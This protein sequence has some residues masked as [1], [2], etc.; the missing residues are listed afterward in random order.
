MFIL[1]IRISINM[2]ELLIYTH[3]HTH[4]HTAKRVQLLKID[5]QGYASVMPLQDDEIDCLTFSEKREQCTLQL[6]LPVC[7]ENDMWKYQQDPGYAP[8]VPRRES[9]G[10]TQSQGN[11]IV[12]SAIPQDYEVPLNCLPSIEQTSRRNSHVLTRQR[13]LTPETSTEDDQSKRLSHQRASDVGTHYLESDHDL[14]D[15]EE[16]F[17]DSGI[18]TSVDSQD[19]VLKEKKRWNQHSG[20]SEVKTSARASSLGNTGTVVE[21]DESYHRPRAITLHNVTFRG[22]DKDQGERPKSTALRI[23]LDQ[24]SQAVV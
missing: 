6:E 12:P 20:G 24:T 4:T 23:S 2:C 22:E 10:S 1:Q 13:A 18:E 21:M 9:G 3:T 19:Q 17:D 11:N 5:S 14:E 7:S 16:V 8:L 15:T